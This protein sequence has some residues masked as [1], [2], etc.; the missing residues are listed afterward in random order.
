MNEI[1]VLVSRF[2]LAL[3][4]ANI[5]ASVCWSPVSGIDVEARPAEDKDLKSIHMNKYKIFFYMSA[6]YK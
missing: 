5:S 1:P 3:M 4:K 6:Y 2:C